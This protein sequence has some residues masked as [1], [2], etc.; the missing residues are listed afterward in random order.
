MA[1]SKDCINIIKNGLNEIRKQRGQELIDDAYVVKQFEA[2]FDDLDLRL[3]QEGLRFTD[4]ITKNGEVVRDAEGNVKTYQDEFVENVINHNDSNILE[5]L[6]LERL[7][8]V[9][10]IQ[11]MQK[12]DRLAN[13]LTERDPTKGFLNDPLSILPFRK[14]KTYTEEEQLNRAVQ[15]LLINTNDVV[16]HV[17]LE[18]II[19]NGQK[20]MIANFQRAIDDSGVLKGERFEDWLKTEKNDTDMSNEFYTMNE[21]FRTNVNQVTDNDQAYKVAQIFFDTVVR[22]SAADLK[23][24]GRKTGIATKTRMATRFDYQKVIKEST[25]QEF[26]DF[27]IDKVRRY[28]IKQSDGDFDITEEIIDVVYDTIKDTKQGWRKVN[29]NVGDL[30]RTYYGEDYKLLKQDG[31]IKT[32]LSFID[33]NARRQVVDRY[34]NYNTGALEFMGTILENARER[35]MTQFFGPRYERVFGQL[36]KQLTVGE[37]V[38][39]E[40]IGGLL[41]ENFTQLT[42][43]QRKVARSVFGFVDSTYVN[44][45]HGETDKFASTMSALRNVQNISKLGSASVTS[46]LDTPTFSYTG[47]RLFGLDIDGLIAGITRTNKFKG[48]KAQVEMHRRLTLDA[49]SGFLNKV[50]ERFG[51]VDSLG[52]YS[53]FEKGSAQYARAIF[54]LSGLTWW[55][56]SLQSAAANVYARSLGI[57]VT[58]RTAWNSLNK[59]FRSQLKRY[60]VTEEDWSF[61]LKKRPLN[62]DGMFDMN[63]LRQIEDQDFDSVKL[64]KRLGTDSV[65][66]KMQAVMNDAVDTMVIKPGDFD[67]LATAWFPDEF[68]GAGSQ[69]AKMLT[70]FK[71]HPITYYRKVIAR[72]FLKRKLTD[73]FAFDQ[74]NRQL[75]EN[76]AD[77]AVITGLMVTVGALV[78]QLKQAVS[79]KQ[80]YKF[81]SPTLWARAA[82]TS[83]A[84]GILS[85]LY[86]TVGG[87]E[88]LIAQIISPNKEP[89]RTSSE[90]IEQLLGPLV[91]DIGKIL[92]NFQ[93]ITLGKVREGKGIDDGELVSKGFSNLTKFVL[94]TAGFK[95]LVLTKAL[96][97]IFVTEYLTEFMDP[98]GYYRTQSRLDTEAFDERIGGKKN[99]TQIQDVASTLT[100][101]A[102]D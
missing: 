11:T 3:N 2:D 13:F 63:H 5:N 30:I 34:S 96:Y 27:M 59:N 83:G 28:K 16:G 25:R 12:I 72:R 55:T 6:E 14:A 89:I 92:D 91:V 85:D 97:R 1:L 90:K 61:M 36:K 42:A 44:P 18:L 67:I 23:I 99:I 37:R 51:A 39:G 41:G 77:I 68:A 20:T 71:T 32:H 26:R 57:H 4:P 35:G 58:Q 74:P 79:G 75:V 8:T 45:A 101:G 53:K 38:D 21:E 33:G 10:G 69:I 62:E 49:M 80:G 48:T 64:R 98:D 29:K 50:G 86:L 84:F 15:A 87:G 54:K 100:F 93:K 52:A 102:I 73:D 81:D 7:D 22:D 9:K 94:D 76:V 40:Q 70:Q 78:V 60:G 95:N 19:K 24:M 56:E 43:F 47:K 88:D 46:I 17:P 31:N 65:F 66:Q 82:T